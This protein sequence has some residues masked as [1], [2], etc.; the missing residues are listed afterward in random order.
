MHQPRPRGVLAHGAEPTDDDNAF[1]ELTARRLTNLKHLSGVSSLRMVKALPDGGY[2]IAQDMGGVFKCITHKPGQSEEPPETFDG[3]AQDYIPMLFSGVVK[4]AILQPEQGLGMQLTEETR[5][6]IARYPEEDQQDEQ[7]QVPADV[8]LQRFRIK[9]HQRFFEFEPKNPGILTYTQ[10]VQQRPTWYSGAMAE[11]M[12]IVGGYG[13]QDFDK[14]PSDRIEQARMALPKEVQDKVRLE[15]GNVRLP[16]YTGRPPVDGQFRYDYKFNNTDAVVFDSEQSP[17]LVRVSPKGVYAMPLPIVPASTT[18]TFRE[19]MEEK[20]DSEIIKILDRFGGLPSGESFPILSEDFEAWRRAGVI[21]KVCDTADFYQHIAYSTACGWS[22]NSTGSQGYNTCY[23]YYDS[24]GLGYGLAYKLSLRLGSNPNNGRLPRDWHI[25]SDHEMNRLNMYLSGL[26]RMMDGNTAKD[27][28]IKYKLRRVSVDE[29]LDRARWEV[30]EAELEYWDAKEM[31]PIASHSGSVVEI[32]RGYLYH[33]A[34]FMYQPQ[35][36]Y[37]E[38]IMGGCVSHDFLPLFNGR[39]KSSYPNCDTIMFCYFT[40]DDLKVVKYFRDGRSYQRDVENDYEECMIVGSWTQTVSNSST[41][42]MGHFYTSD[43]DERKAITP[44]ETFTK[45]VGRD[46]GYDHTPRFAF[47]APYWKPGTLSRN[48]Y[49]THDTY[50]RYSEGRSLEVAV[51]VPYLNRNSLIHVQ[52]SSTTE[53]RITES[54]QLKSVRD[55]TSYRYWTYDF[56]MHWAG[57][58]PVMSGKPYPKDGNPVW[59]EIEQY[60]PGGCSD[61]A[62]QGSWIPGLPA[63]YTWLVRPDSNEWKLSGGGGAPPHKDYSRTTKP[64]TKQAYRMDY[65]QQTYPKLVHKNKPDN[66]YFLGSPDP[67]VGVFYRDGCSVTFGDSEYANLSEKVDGKRKHWG[68]TSLA[69]HKSA[70][71]FIGVINE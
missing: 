62:D 38:P 40:G 23:D 44:S 3:V 14:L 33:P 26:Y 8:S 67:Y 50:T 45:I 4:D 27:L 56:V 48:R 16:G 31:S 22:F 68:Y 29:L 70:H 5:R 21:I 10:Y 2:M 36:K 46:K 41:S 17:W 63:D 28:A 47:D 49:F 34:K 55:P 24:E 1:I 12:Q 30:D 51:C 66:M 53:E 69:D 18:D 6:R 11:V 35:I 25:E 59:V 32:G 39:Y 9:Y 52:R 15:L 42:L 61:F 64:D 13:R 7:A 20:G 60:N 65:S 37:P 54:S 57:G 58:L 43:L 19:F 71:H